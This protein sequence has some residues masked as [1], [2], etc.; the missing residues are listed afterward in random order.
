MERVR[1]LEN[2]ADEDE[3]TAEALSDPDHAQ[4]HRKLVAVQRKDAERL[5]TFLINSRLRQVV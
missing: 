4:R 5:L 1:E 2:A 3:R